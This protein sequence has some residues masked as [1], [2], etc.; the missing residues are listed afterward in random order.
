[1]G[2]LQYRQGTDGTCLV[3][4]RVASSCG[5]GYARCNT[6]LQDRCAASAWSALP[7]ECRFTGNMQP[8]VLLVI[9]PTGFKTKS[10]RTVLDE[11]GTQYEI[12][13]FHAV[14]QALSMVNVEQALSSDL[15]VLNWGLPYMHARPKP[16]AG[17]AAC[18]V[19]RAPR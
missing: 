8:P 13:E 4:I 18:V 9:D 2:R 19:S 3:N 1:M 5:V 7:I 12:K 17:F 15:V 10:I 16:F 6:Q 11:L 14:V